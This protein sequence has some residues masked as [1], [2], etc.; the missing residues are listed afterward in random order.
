M[1]LADAGVEKIFA[2]CSEEKMIV[3]VIVLDIKRSKWGVGVG[4]V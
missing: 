4:G 1:S 2:W 3:L